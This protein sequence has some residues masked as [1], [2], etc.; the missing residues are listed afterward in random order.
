VANDGVAGVVITAVGIGRICV[1]GTLAGTDV[2]GIIT[3]VYPVMVITL[4]TVD[5]TSTEGIRTG[6]LETGTEVGMVIVFKI[7]DETGDPVG[8]ETT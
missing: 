2:A 8:I 1:V 6:E 7:V 5:G 3:T 4:V